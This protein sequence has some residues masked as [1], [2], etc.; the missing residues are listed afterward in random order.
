[1]LFKSNKYNQKR[2]QSLRYLNEIKEKASSVQTTTETPRVSGGSGLRKVV[3][4]KRF[5]HLVW[6][7]HK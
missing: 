4:R 2:T 6:S 1:M 5:G 3:L 7:E